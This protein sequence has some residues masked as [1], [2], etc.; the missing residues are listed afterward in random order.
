MNQPARIGNFTSSGIVALLSM[1]KIEMTPEE[2][3]ARPKTGTGSSAKLKEGG[4][5]EAAKTYIKECNWERKA[6]R[7]MEQEV[8]SKETAWGK[9]NEPRVMNILGGDYIRT[10]TETAL[11]HPKY[12]FWK[13][14]PDGQKFNLLL[15]EKVAEVKCPFT[16]TS[17][18]TFADCENIEDVREK[19]KSGEMYYWQVVSN[20]CILGL[21]KAEL[22]IYC[23]Y[24][25]ELME[26]RQEAEICPD[27][28]TAK[29]M[30]RVNPSSLPYLIRGKGYESIKI[31]DF[32]V[33]Q[34]DKD[35]LTERVIE[36]GKLLNNIN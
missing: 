32:V 5:G 25:D 7:S 29:W 1:G 17:F 19:H 9:L 11:T 30:E 14:S 3:A 20:A 8:W 23:P 31:F 18:F 22:I 15:P 13:G 21:D 33:P 10:G 24:E 2:L 4:L 34:A 36:C 12:D 6:G 27:I 16:L 26:I 28:D 35:R